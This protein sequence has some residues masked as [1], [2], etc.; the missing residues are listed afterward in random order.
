MQLINV[1]KAHTSR[2]Y[3]LDVDQ[4]NQYLAT[5]GEDAMVYVYE[6]A[7]GIQSAV[8]FE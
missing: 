3:C 8:F 4:T 6:M 1:I 5:G 2:C 7:T